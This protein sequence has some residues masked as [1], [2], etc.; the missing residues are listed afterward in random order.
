MLLSW[1][2]RHAIKMAVRSGRMSESFGL[3][4]TDVANIE[5]HVGGRKSAAGQFYIDAGDR[6]S[7]AE[8]PLPR[9]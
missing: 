4:R 7:T 3:V 9:T 1:A 6:C 2:V 5:R 8:T